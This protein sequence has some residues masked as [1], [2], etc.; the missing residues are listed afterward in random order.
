MKYISKARSDEHG[1]AEI[2]LYD[3]NGKILNRIDKVSKSSILYYASDD[4]KSGYSDIS[5]VKA[6]M[7]CR[8]PTDDGENVTTDNV[9]ILRVQGN[10][11]VV[12][13]DFDK[14]AYSV[15]IGITKF[16]KDGE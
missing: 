11:V 13:M 1:K 9:E 12:L 2:P 3:K 8:I 10:N 16:T 5:G 14:T 4:V 7:E 15:Y 6:V